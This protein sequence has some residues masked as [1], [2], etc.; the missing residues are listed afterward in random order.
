[1]ILYADDSVLVCADNDIHKLKSETE[2]ELR[3]IEDWTRINKI[4]LNYKK[5][6][7]VTY[8]KYIG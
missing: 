2:A 4:S 8:T 5:K 7:P 3:K 1:M 6:L